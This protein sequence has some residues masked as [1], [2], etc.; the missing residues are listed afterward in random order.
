[1]WTTLLVAA[2]AFFLSVY[3]PGYA[4]G[5]ALCAIQGY[6]EHARGTTSHYGRVYNALC[7]NDGYHAEHHAHPALHWSELPRRQARDGRASRWPPLLRVL[8]NF[9]LEALERSVIRSPWLQTAVLR[10]H[11]TAFS[12]LLPRRSL[13]PSRAS[14]HRGRR[15]R[16]VSADRSR[17]AGAD[18]G[19]ANHGDRR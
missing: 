14:A 18:T 1:L 11:R 2:P 16:P 3:L 9:A 7:F 6:Y 10:V 4:A 15:R 5:L 19:R 12:D 8:D 17:P 13:Q